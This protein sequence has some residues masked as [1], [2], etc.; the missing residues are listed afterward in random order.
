MDRFL[1]VL[2]LSI[3]INSNVED[4][5]LTKFSDISSMTPLHSF[6]KVS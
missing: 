5:I 4:N 3:S 2:I 1:R 6:Q